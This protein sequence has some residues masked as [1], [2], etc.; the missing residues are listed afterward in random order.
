MAELSPKQ[1]R[2]C[3]EY[4][5]DL[6]ATQAAIR[7]GYRERSARQ[8]AARLLT[9]DYIQAEVARLRDDISVR[10]GLT[11][12]RVLNEIGS[13]AFAVASDAYNSELRY[14]SKLK[15]LEM[16]AKHLGL[17]DEHR[18][19]EDSGAGGV[20]MLGEAMPEPEPPGGDL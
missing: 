1:L 14:S 15:A 20:I 19:G 4:L 9:K 10:T 6:N 16:L 2:F 3:E 12:D 17:F 18:P 7:A 5:V 13:V 8:Q 11:Q